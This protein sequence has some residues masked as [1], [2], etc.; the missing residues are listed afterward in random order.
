ML[1]AFATECYYCHYTMDVTMITLRRDSIDYA[2]MPYHAAD[3]AAIRLQLM[4]LHFAI[5]LVML[6]HAIRRCCR[7]YRDD[8]LLITFISAT[9]PHSDYFRYFIRAIRCR[10]CHHQLPHARYL[11]C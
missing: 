9:M 10:C 2:D 8:T 11:R 7:S 5:T 3:A 4:I 1:I 6:R